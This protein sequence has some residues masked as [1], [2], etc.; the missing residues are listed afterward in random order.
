MPGSVSSIE[1][2]ADARTVTIAAGRTVTLLD[3]T[4]FAPLHSFAAGIDVS[5][6]SLSPD[7]TRLVAGGSDFWVH[8]Y[9]VTEGQVGKELDVFKGHHGP[10]HCIRFS[11][12]GEM[13]ASGSE[14]G[15]IRLWQTRPGTA[16]GLWLGAGSQPKT[17]GAL[18][19]T[20][21]MS[22]VSSA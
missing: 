18:V 20:A 19:E 4:S 10:V 11:P 14:D 5:S 13:Y 8:A 15:T 7:R 2:S 17:A 21:S 22:S 12:D 3:A 6:A 16:Y 1:V 9:D